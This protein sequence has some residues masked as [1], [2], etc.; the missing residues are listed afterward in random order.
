MTDGDREHLGVIG[1]EVVAD[2]PAPYTIREE[3]R[4]VGDGDLRPLD[5]WAFKR[6]E[7]TAG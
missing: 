5:F 3:C 7:E 2:F 4:S 6:A 1:T